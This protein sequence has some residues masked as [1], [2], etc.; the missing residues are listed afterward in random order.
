MRGF[1]EAE[2]WASCLQCL[3][4]LCSHFSHPRGETWQFCYVVKEV[5]C[6]PWRSSSCTGSNIT[7]FSRGT[8]SFGTLWV[9]TVTVSSL[10]KWCFTCS[11]MSVSY[12]HLVAVNMNLTYQI[13]CNKAWLMCFV[14]NQCYT[15]YRKC[16]FCTTLFSIIVSILISY[17]LTVWLTLSHRESSSFH[18]DSWSDGWP[19]WINTDK[20]STLRLTV[21]LRQRHQRLATK[22]WKRGQVPAIRLPGNQVSGQKLKTL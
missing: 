21:P 1:T 16:L 2:I 19:A 12:L 17:E 4:Q 20:G 22:H 7:V 6:F 5:W 9:S 18:G 13:A 3:Y 14:N 8:C 11:L 10:K 15:L